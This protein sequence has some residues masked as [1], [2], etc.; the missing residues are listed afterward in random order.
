MNRLTLLA[1]RIKA[2]RAAALRVQRPYSSGSPL[3]KRESALEEQFIL[4]HEKEVIAKLR[5]DLAEREKRLAEKI[6]EKQAGASTTQKKQGSSEAARSIEDEKIHLSAMGASTGSSFAKREAAAE[7]QYFRKLEHD[8]VED[9]KHH[10]K[11][12]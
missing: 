10:K 4:E 1:A 12:E 11:K 5:K 6:K 7:E 8:K 9:L 2:P 3:G